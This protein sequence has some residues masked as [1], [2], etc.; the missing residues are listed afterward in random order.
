MD[1]INCLY[2]ERNPDLLTKRLKALGFGYIIFDYNTYALSADPDGTL[3][4]KYQAVLE[5]ILNYTDIAIH[6]YFKGYLTV[7]IQGTDQ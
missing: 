5:Y 6:D 7:K 3:N 4:E 1:V 2:Q